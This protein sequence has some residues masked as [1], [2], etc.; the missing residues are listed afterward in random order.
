MI[1]QHCDS[2]LN[3]PTTRT[4]GDYYGAKQGPADRQFSLR[5]KSQRVSHG[6][7]GQ[8]VEQIYW[9][10]WDQTRSA[11]T[12]KTIV[13]TSITMSICPRSTDNLKVISKN[14]HNARAHR[15]L[16]TSHLSLSLIGVACRH[17]T[18]CNHAAAERSFEC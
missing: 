7:F 4:S 2:P 10:L 9:R 17:A 18:G 11:D 3:T 16:P 13:V 1:A 6:L 12:W 8:G 5:G 14:K 15:T